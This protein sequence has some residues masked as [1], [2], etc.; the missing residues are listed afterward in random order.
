[1][2]LPETILES[3]GGVPVA[4]DHNDQGRPVGMA[5]AGTTPLAVLALEGMK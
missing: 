2:S 3:I 5:N 1:M 4:T